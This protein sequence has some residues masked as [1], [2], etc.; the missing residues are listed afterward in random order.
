MSGTGGTVFDRATIADEYARESHLQPAEEAILG[1]LLPQLP[2]AAMLDL[3]VGGGRTTLHFA[4]WVRSYVGVDLSDTMIERCERRFAAYPT[5]VTFRSGDA[6]ELP[7]DE[8]PYIL[9]TGRTLYNY[10]IG[11]MTQKAGAIR[12]KQQSNFVELH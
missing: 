4:K 10:N 11:N 3:G 9:S 7:D 1:R 6:A 12:Q 2:A 5:H 8:Y